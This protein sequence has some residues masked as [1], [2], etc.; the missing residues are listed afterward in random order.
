LDCR[1]RL[2]H[3]ATLNQLEGFLMRAGVLAI[4][5]ST[6]CCAR[7]FRAS[8][9]SAS[10]ACT[11]R[12]TWPCASARRCAARLRAVTIP[13]QLRSRGTPGAR[14]SS[15]VPTVGRR[16]GGGPERRVAGV[17]FRVLVT[18]DCH[19]WLGDECLEHQWLTPVGRRRLG[20]QARGC[21]TGRLR[22]TTSWTA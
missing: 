1:S 6:I 18:G 13:P 17:V 15:K 3:Q 22:S 5:A 12:R 4:D 14:W 8:T 20:R 9:T 2:T 16:R 7:S 10:G 21:A 11:A 19:D